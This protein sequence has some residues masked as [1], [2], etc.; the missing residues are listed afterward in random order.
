MICFCF[1][2]F[3][4][5]LLFFIFFSPFIDSR[6]RGRDGESEEKNM[7][8]REKHLLVASHMRPNWGPNPQL[9][10]TLWLESK[11]VTF[12]FVE[13]LPTNWTTLARAL[14]FQVTY[15]FYHSLVFHIFKLFLIIKIFL[16][17]ISF[18]TYPFSCFILNLELSRPAMKYNLVTSLNYSCG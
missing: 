3:L 5:F 4:N 13:Q 14:I 2:F 8:V 12:W 1:L 6:E 10:H 18:W 16:Q 7:D 17:M 11:L 15:I 9:R